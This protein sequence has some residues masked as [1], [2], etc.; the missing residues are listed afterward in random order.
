VNQ[1]VLRSLIVSLLIM[2]TSQIAHAA[3][4]SPAKEFKAVYSCESLSSSWKPEAN[5]MFLFWFHIHF[6]GETTTVTDPWFTYT[7][8]K[9]MYYPVTYNREPTTTT[10]TSA[11]KGDVWLF[12]WVRIYPGV[13]PIQ[14]RELAAEFSTIEKVGRLTYT[15]RDNLIMV[16]P[17]TCSQVKLK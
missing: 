9:I 17:F 6:D 5:P 3:L 11:K 13:E 16:R 7:S 14:S 1:I 8:Y 10:M 15:S 4:Y 12:N 2:A